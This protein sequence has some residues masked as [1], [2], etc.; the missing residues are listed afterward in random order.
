MQKAERTRWIALAGVAVLIA[1]ALVCGGCSDRSS[2]AATGSSSTQVAATS[3]AAPKDA[4]KQPTRDITFDTV[5]F[6]I[7]KDQPFVRSM[8]TPAIE[9]LHNMPVRIRGFILPSFQQ[10]GL[11][12]FVL[13]R[14]NMECCFG[15]GAALYDCIVVEMQPGKSTDFTTHPVAVEGTFTIHELR[16]PEDRC[17]AVY[18]LEGEKVR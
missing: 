10:T 3:S 15:P 16:S 7:Q 11:T 6:D 9:K 5:K 4:E 12:Q 14:D 1:A 8:L 13:V 17:M 18:H 2:P